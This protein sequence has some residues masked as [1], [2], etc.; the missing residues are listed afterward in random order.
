[1]FSC[2]KRIRRTQTKIISPHE[3][4]ENWKASLFSNPVICECLINTY[5]ENELYYAEASCMYKKKENE[6]IGIVKLCKSSLIT[7]ETDV[8]T[9]EECSICL[10]SLQKGKHK[11]YS[12][13]SGCG[14]MFHTKCIQRHIKTQKKSDN[15]PSC[16]LC[17]HIEP[18]DWDEIVRRK[19]LHMLRQG[20]E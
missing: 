8:K 5:F 19:K 12:K 3:E 20:L 13:I 18:N 16:P 15:R 9:S 4:F 14:H 10:E 6:P 2:F 7:E 17:R 11:R 1:M